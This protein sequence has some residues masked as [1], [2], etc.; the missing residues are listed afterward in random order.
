MIKK[1]GH[2]TL[3]NSPIWMVWFQGLSS[4]TTKP[5][6]DECFHR[7]KTLNTDRPVCILDDITIQDYC[8]E[9]YEYLKETKYD[10]SFQARSDLLRLLLLEKYGGTWADATLFPV[11]SLGH[12]EGQLQTASGFF[13]YRFSKIRRSQLKGDRMTCSWFLHSPQSNNYII[14]K[15]KEA[16]LEY[17]IGS[18][19]W[20]YFSIH[21]AFCDMY[22]SNSQF[23][24][25]IDK[26]ELPLESGPHILKKIK[27]DTPISRIGTECNGLKL[28]FVFKEPRL[29]T[30]PFLKTATTESSLPEIISSI[31]RDLAS[32]NLRKR[33]N[34]I[35]KTSPDRKSISKDPVSFLHIGKCGGTSV[36]A[37]LRSQQSEFNLYHR[38]RP[39]LDT[40][41]DSKY[42]FFIRDPIK[43]FVSAFDMA[44]SIVN[45]DFQSVTDPRQLNLSNC[46]AP[47]RIRRFLELHKKH[48]INERYEFLLDHFTSATHLAESLSSTDHQ[49]CSY[50]H[51]LLSH[52]SEH[53]FK[54]IGWY[55][56]NGKFIDARS[57][58]IFFVGCLESFDSDLIKL[59]NLLGIQPPD[60]VYHQRK[61]FTSNKQDLSPLACKNLRAW[62]NHTDY[63]AIKKLYHYNLI[64]YDQY[65]MYA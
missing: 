10:R 23:S 59:C 5:I 65:S 57:Q 51:E 35:A 55:L 27:K 48:V 60:S 7:W 56:H 16:F 53:M 21:Q 11:F 25:L 22:Y 34:P 42:F 61:G 38:K 62:Y 1:S 32:P 18:E 47:K 36:V 46:P 33:D 58:Q 50:A 63:A 44:K 45:Y 6:H 14:S 13:A 41:D 54:G 8:P 19:K 9:Y 39:S 24:E 26:S 12:I 40:N 64:S 2:M 3:P 37:Y 28:P 52:P 30:L 43:R 49:V 17:F 4:N 29:F 15:W 31:Y 20:K